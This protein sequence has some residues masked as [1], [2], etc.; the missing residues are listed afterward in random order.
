MIT[1]LT[2]AQF[3]VDN[4]SEDEGVK[5]L[6]TILTIKSFQLPNFL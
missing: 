3:D 2:A 1:N 4:F 5:R 6:N